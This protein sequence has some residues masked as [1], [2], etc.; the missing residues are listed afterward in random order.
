VAFADTRKRRF[1]GYAG[2][3]GRR[4]SAFAIGATALVLAACGGDGGELSEAELRE[5]GNAICAK[6]ET[7]IDELTTPSSV[8][9]IPA[10]VE[11]AAPIVQQEIEEL[12]ALEPPSED[13]ETFDQMIAA[14]EKTLV[15]GRDLSDAAEE[16]DDAAIEQA[17]NEGNAAS[18]QADRHAQALGLS[19]CVDEGQ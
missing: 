12:K 16:N 11:K 9:E 18:D 5:Q 17:L 19:E 7:Q 3:T 1:V 6:Y 10:Y 14:A 2:L 8:E 13:Q 4:A 15:A